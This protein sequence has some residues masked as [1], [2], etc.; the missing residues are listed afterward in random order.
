MLAGIDRAVDVDVGVAVDR[1]V[2]EDAIEDV[3]GVRGAG[4]VVRVPGPLRMERDHVV[5][6]T[7]R[8]RGT[9]AV[10][11]GRIPRLQRVVGRGVRQRLVEDRGD[12][13]GVREG[14][15]RE[16]AGDDA[17]DVDVAADGDDDRL[18]DR[19]PE[20]DQVAELPPDVGR[21]LREL[22]NRR[23]IDPA[24]GEAGR[25]RVLGIA[26]GE[27]VAGGDRIV[28]PER[29]REVID[30][31][32]R[33]HAGGANRRQDLAVVRDRGLVRERVELRQHGGGDAAA[34]RRRRPSTTGR[35]GSTR[36]TA[37]RCW[38]AGVAAPAGRRSRRGR[39]NPGRLPAGRR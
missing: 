21:I 34:R 14:A 16:I 2:E 27:R 7:D 11:V 24:A 39:R 20:I 32:E 1:G 19:R 22:G 35:C 8:R 5:D 26:A 33:L 17:G 15:R 25:R 12:G 31:D 13:A 6:E 18:V 23:R 29:Q 9:V 28:D 30:G 10:G 4:L 38:R 3:V 36:A 37:G